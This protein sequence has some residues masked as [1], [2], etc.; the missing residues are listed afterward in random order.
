MTPATP[1]SRAT[2]G[3]TGSAVDGERS[4]RI[5][6]HIGGAVG[7]ASLQRVAEA[8]LELNSADIVRAVTRA[9]A[10]THSLIEMSSGV[11]IK[12]PEVEVL[13]GKNRTAAC[14]NP[15][16]SGV[17]AHWITA[18]GQMERHIALPL[19]TDLEFTIG[20]K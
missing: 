5:E 3:A 16:G 4:A 17:G 19:V 7:E 14:G 15:Q 12:G 6:R 18:V 9:A 13:A 1:S 20:V 2:G 11:E 10:I 8:S